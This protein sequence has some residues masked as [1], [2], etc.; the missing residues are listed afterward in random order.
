MA[1]AQQLNAK[2]QQ[3]QRQQ[4]QQWSPLWSAGLL[5]GTIYLAAKAVPQV[6]NFANQLTQGAVNVDEALTKAKDGE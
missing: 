1:T 5:A 3:E 4:Q 6:S 2:Q